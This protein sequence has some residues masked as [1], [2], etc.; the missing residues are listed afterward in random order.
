MTKVSFEFSGLEQEACEA[1]ASDPKL[2]AIFERIAKHEIAMPDYQEKGRVN[3]SGLR[4]SVSFDGAWTLTIDCSGD[5]Q[6]D[7]NGFGGASKTLVDVNA[8]VLFAK[9]NCSGLEQ[10]VIVDAVGALVED[11]LLTGE[12]ISTEI[13]VSD[14][15]IAT[16]YWR[17]PLSY[18]DDNALT[19]MDETMLKNLDRREVE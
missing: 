15:V 10:E 14:D 13:C 6:E 3:I 5:L 16:V 19:S 12:N 2:I 9:M 4:T 17:P 18:Y 7:W 8:P 11:I 1:L